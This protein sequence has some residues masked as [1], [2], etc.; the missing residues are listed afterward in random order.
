MG[1][2][3]RTQRGERPRWVQK[4][5]L[6]TGLQALT[7]VP[8]A[9]KET[10][11]KQVE[12]SRTQEAQPCPAESKDPWAQAKTCTSQ[13]QGMAPAHPR[14]AHGSSDSSPVRLR[15]QRRHII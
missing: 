12:M 4:T 8:G 6:E 5:E 2:A 10:E 13:R 9:E 15:G 11:E 1:G 14:R 7:W 3:S